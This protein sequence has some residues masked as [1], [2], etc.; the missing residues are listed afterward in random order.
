MEM[1]FLVTLTSAFVAALTTLT[2]GFL[3][4]WSGE[5]RERLT[6]QYLFREQQLQKFYAPIL[7]RLIELSTHWQLAE[8]LTENQKELLKKMGQGGDPSKV[9]KPAQDYVIEV[10]KRQNE[11]LE[12]IANITRENFHLAEASTIAEATN[13]FRSNLNRKSVSFGF[14][15]DA[16]GEPIPSLGE[17]FPPSLIKFMMDIQ[18]QYNRLAKELR[19]AQFNEIQ[20]SDVSKIKTDFPNLLEFKSADTTVFLEKAKDNSETRN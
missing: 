6:R 10:H 1:V 12:E 13:I 5:Q 16:S 14:P 11:I 15:I 17:P 20:V 7:S 4:H 18:T 19:T 8:K 2:V 9:M 3:T